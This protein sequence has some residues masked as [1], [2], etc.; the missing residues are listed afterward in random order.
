MLNSNHLQEALKIFSRSIS[1][2]KHGVKKYKGN[3]KQICRQIVKD[4]W[5]GKYFQVS[6]GH[7]TSFY[8]RDFGWCV[9]SLLK[10][11]YKDKVVKTLDWALDIYSKKRLTTTITP[12]RRCVDIFAYSPDSLAFL[13]RS[14][15]AANAKGLVEEYRCF[16]G[17]EVNNYY[18][19]VIDPDT[20]LV[21][22]NRR[23][24]SMK[25]Q[26]IRRSS[27][28]NN[29]MTAMLSNELDQLGFRNPFANYDLEKIIKE[30]FWT[31]KYFLDDLS[32]KKYVAGDANVLPFWSNVFNDKRMLKNSISAIQKEGL[33]KPFPLKY[34]TENN[35][36][37][38]LI[39]VLVSNYEGNVSWM[40]M[41]PLYVQLV[42]QIDKK[43]AK[44]YIDIYTKLI[45]KHKNFLEV[46]NPDA[47]PFKSPFYHA[48]EGMLWSA[49]YLTL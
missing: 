29:I 18:N 48:D 37:K 13:V 19:K 46:F 39:R 40:H 34:T 33:D 5:N 10:L 41:G 20:G 25:D 28:Y 35:K 27:C 4:C 43:K 44:E 6:N 11:G 31:G 16:I 23:F 12:Y 47:T 15:R 3:A 26:A 7:F 36:K 14:L 24:S 30:R 21:R 45:E 1:V 49:N 42:K 2:K 22:T 9:D 8:M 32:G 17:E 38:N